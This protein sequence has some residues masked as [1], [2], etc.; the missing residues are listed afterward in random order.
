LLA[1][2]LFGNVLV[3]G[4]AAFFLAVEGLAFTMSRIAEPD[5]YTIAFLLGA[6]FCLLSAFYRWRS[7]AP[8]RSRGA[9]IGWLVAVGLLAGAGGASKWVALYGFVAICLFLVWDGLR[10]GRDGMW[11]VAGSPMASLFVFALCLGVIPVLVYITT[12]IPYLSL[13]HSFGE[14]FDLQGQMY[15]YHAHLN[16][17]HP[18]SSPWFG[19][20]FGYRAVFFY[21]AGSGAERS[22]I[23]TIPNLV[24]FW[25]GLLAMGAAVRRARSTRST[26][27][28]IVVFAALMQFL[29]WVSVGRVVFLYHYLPVVPF[30]AIA[31]AWLLA[32]DL[33]ETRYWKPVMVAT[34]AGAAV[35]FIA[36]LPMLSGWKV[37]VKY[38]D[39][40]RAA[41]FWVIP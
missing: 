28:A 21:L 24:V 23:W 7:D 17:T 27:L 11:G 40:V 1:L 4:L 8:A 26:A 9:A 37:P 16:A 3:A 19:W 5:S 15:A 25:G 34:V 6:W 36:V 22:E 31:L 10:H 32:V 38:L 14:L 39:D 2:R 33:R 41:L 13:G 12:Y 30:L 18:F 29:P 20:P 35:F